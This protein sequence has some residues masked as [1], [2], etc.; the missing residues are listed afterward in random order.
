MRDRKIKLREMTVCEEFLPVC[1]AISGRRRSLPE[2]TL[3]SIAGKKKGAAVGALA[4]RLEPCAPTR[5]RV[6]AEPLVA[7]ALAYRLEP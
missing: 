1:A 3:T 7:D 2:K 4:Y 6:K 5:A